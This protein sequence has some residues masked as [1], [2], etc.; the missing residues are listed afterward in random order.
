MGS[1][2][3]FSGTFWAAKAHFQSV[4]DAK[5]MPRLWQSV[6]VNTLLTIVCAIIIIV[7]YIY[8]QR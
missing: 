7:L 3:V 5:R 8:S 6:A 1:I 2:P 4:Q